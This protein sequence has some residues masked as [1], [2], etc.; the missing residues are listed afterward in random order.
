MNFFLAWNFKNKLAICSLEAA[1]PFLMF[2]DLNEVKTSVI[3]QLL[4]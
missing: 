3:G 1:P 4:L 2:V